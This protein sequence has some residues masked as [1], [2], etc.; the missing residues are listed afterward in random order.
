MP[1]SP[2]GRWSIRITSYNV[3]YTKLLRHLFL[4]LCVA[5]GLLLTV[6]F[7]LDTWFYRHEGHEAPT[8]EPEEKIGIE[9]K[10]N[11]LLLGGVVL[12]VLGSGLW[13]H[14]V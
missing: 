8:D 9:G 10:V 1:G 13:P 11:I 4:P 3:C 12:S 7:A 14:V 6:F 2:P 5:S